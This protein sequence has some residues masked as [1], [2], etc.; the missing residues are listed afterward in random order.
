MGVCLDK[1][2]FKEV[3][4][5]HCYG[6]NKYLIMKELVYSNDIIDD[7]FKKI[8]HHIILSRHVI[9]VCDKWY[10]NSNKKSMING[11]G[12]PLFDS[13]F[14]RC[15]CYKYNKFCPHQVPIAL[16]TTLYRRIIID[17]P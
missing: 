15:W 4:K 17:K 11:F 9:C 2:I 5:I 13:L 3:N 1:E 16:Q 8:F 12:E 10:A 7:I 6:F 14:K